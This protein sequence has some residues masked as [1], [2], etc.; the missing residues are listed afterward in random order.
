MTIEFA[1][2]PEHEALREA[3]RAFAQKEIA[4]VVVD[5]DEKEQFPAA[6]VARMKEEGYFGVPI[7]EEYGGLG[8]GKVGY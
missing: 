4:P 3:V 8:M 5:M 1:F 2:T 7:P 6:T